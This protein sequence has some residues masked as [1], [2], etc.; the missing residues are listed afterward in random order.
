MLATFVDRKSSFKGL[1]RPRSFNTQLGISLPAM[2]FQLHCYTS[3][4]RL[5]LAGEEHHAKRRRQVPRQLKDR[6]MWVI[7]Q[8]GASCF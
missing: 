4:P 3:G 6:E 2:G 1:R 5:Q 7:W 8:F